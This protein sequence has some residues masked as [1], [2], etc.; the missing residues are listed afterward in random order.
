[1]ACRKVG[2]CLCELGDYEGA[3]QHQKRHLE[4]AKQL[5]KCFITNLGSKLGRDTIFAVCFWCRDIFAYVLYQGLIKRE[6]MQ[7]P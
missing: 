7:L 6:G 5:R 1:M 4:V 3:V 2:E